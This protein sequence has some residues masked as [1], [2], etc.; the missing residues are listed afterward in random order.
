MDHNIKQLEQHK[1]KIEDDLEELNSQLS[2]LKK[3][4]VDMEKRN[5]HL[6][7]AYVRKLKF[8][9]QKAVNDNID[10][11]KGD[12]AVDFEFDDINNDELLSACV[13]AEGVAKNT[14]EN[15]EIV[16]RTTGCN[17]WENMYS[18]IFM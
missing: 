9:P 13:E 7:S 10:N 6:R 3:H 11:R 17:R 15:V 16:Y 8:S 1:W 4:Y 14:V 2:T 5:T 12:I 18:R